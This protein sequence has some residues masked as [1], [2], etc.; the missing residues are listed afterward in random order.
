MRVAVRIIAWILLFIAIGLLGRDL[1]A[2]ASVG[3]FEITPLGKLWFHID[4]A[5]LNGLQAGIERYLSEALWWYMVEPLLRVPAVLYF[6]I[7]GL[8]LFYVSRGGGEDRRRPKRF[9]RR[10]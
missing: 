3:S 6:L 2:W 5:S 7:P 10:R 8:L 1:I 9:L 4:A